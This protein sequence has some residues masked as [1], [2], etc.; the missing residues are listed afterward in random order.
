[1]ERKKLIKRIIGWALI[2][3]LLPLA[4]MGIATMFNDPNRF[5]AAYFG[6][7]TIM[8]AAVSL[9]AIMKLIEWLLDS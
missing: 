1:M 2:S 9:A 3:Q 8:A 6:G 7:L 4:L 5:M